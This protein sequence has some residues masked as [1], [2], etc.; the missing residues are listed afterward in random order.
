MWR[1]VGPPRG[2]EHAKAVGADDTHP[3]V[4]ADRDQLRLALGAVAAS[5]GEPGRDHDERPHTCA[6]HSVAATPTT[7]SAGTDH[8]CEI[9]RLRNVADR[10]VGGKRLHGVGMRR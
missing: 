5:L 4:P 7:P 3:G 1:S 8:D 2:V 9:D 10:S 6:A